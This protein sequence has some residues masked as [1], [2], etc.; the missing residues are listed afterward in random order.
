MQAEIVKPEDFYE[1]RTRNK[2][3]W[4]GSLLSHKCFCCGSGTRLANHHINPREDGGSDSSRNKV[5]LCSSCHDAVEGM[6]RSAIIARRESIRNERRTQP[7]TSHHTPT[8]AHRSLIAANDI[9]ACSTV[10]EY[11]ALTHTPAAQSLIGRLMVTI[12]AKFPG[13]T[14][15]DARTKAN[16]L[17]QQAAGKYRY[18]TPRVLSAQEQATKTEA[19]RAYFAESRTARTAA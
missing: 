8:V 17:Q 4:G 18:V 12:L 10:D 9:K 3:P 19:T 2:R 1:V 11:F 7:T 15:D 5:T 6:E 14:F 16:E 13:I